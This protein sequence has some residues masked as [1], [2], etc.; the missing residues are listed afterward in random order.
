MAGSG[1]RTQRTVTVDGRKLRLTHLDKVLYPETGTT[2]ADVQ[3]YL[4]AVAPVLLPQS[5]W[6][7]VTRK[8]WPDGV[9]TSDEPQKPFFRKDLEKSAPDWVPRMQLE[10]SDH[11]NTY[12]LAN[13]PAVLAWFGQVA[14]LEIHVPQWRFAPDGTARNPDRL[15]LDLDPGPGTGL[16]DCAELAR[17]CREILTDMG[18]EAVPV[19]SGS[20]GIHLYAALAGGLSLVL[21]LLG[22]VA[23]E[24]LAGGALWFFTYRFSLLP[25]GVTLPFF[26]AL[27]AALPPIALHAARKQTLVERLRVE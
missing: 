10:H 24:T 6:R 11:T 7:P 25:L 18:L 8:R 22:G 16:T 15:V 5:A 17:L 23:V 2:K 4:A 3:E 27:G 26:A 14:A 1:P 12:P 9:G 21:C 19:T 13:D 20:K